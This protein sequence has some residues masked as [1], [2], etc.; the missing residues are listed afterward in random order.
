MTLPACPRLWQVEA[1]RDGRLSGKDL[2]AAERHREHC[3]ECAEE[4]RKLAALRHDLSSTRPLPRNPLSVR[5]SR[6][7]L[8][9]AVNDSLLASPAKGRQAVARALALLPAAALGYGLFLWH[10]APRAALAPQKS[11][12]EIRSI[13]GARWVIQ[14][15]AGLEQVVLS[16][17]AAAFKVHPHPDRRVLVRLPD[18]ELEDL[19]TTFEVAVHDQ[20][21][22][23]IAV[24]DGRVAVRLSSQ[25]PFSL[26]AGEHWE[27][28]PASPTPPPS[29]ALAP[30]TSHFAPARHADPLHPLPR[31]A[32]SAG[33]AQAAP[34]PAPSSALDRDS[35][36]AED[37][38][39]LAVVALL[40]RERYAEARLQAKA[41]LMRF[42][43][44]FRRV[45]MLNVA[46][47]AKSDPQ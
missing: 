36:H 30:P 35:T 43:N 34:A 24:S 32:R 6:Q 13:A 29:V 39:Y 21:T 8:L 2:E 47:S 44:G 42:P 22:S 28:P 27:R 9:A 33:N 38:A 23:H 5:R 17:G 10:S 46:T 45:E 3:S 37:A 12:L 16:D 20:R 19:G 7:R 4:A 41:Y 15:S 31:A 18:G 11:V 1:V 25:P 40:R 26:G 14:N